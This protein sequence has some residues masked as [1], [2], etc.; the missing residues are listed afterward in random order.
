MSQS[1]LTLYF[2]AEGEEVQQRWMD[3]LSRAGRGEE[4]HPQQP[5]IIESL[6]EEGEELVALEIVHTWLYWTRTQ[7]SE[8]DGAK[9]GPL[10]AFKRKH[11]PTHPPTNTHTPPQYSN[12]YINLHDLPAVKQEMVL[13]PLS[14]LV[15]IVVGGV[16][17]TTVH[18][19]LRAAR[20]DSFNMRTLCISLS[21]WFRL[22]LLKNLTAFF[23]SHDWL[24][25]TASLNAAAFCP[26]HE[27]WYWNTVFIIVKKKTKKTEFTIYNRKIC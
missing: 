2:S 11:T 26:I 24:N 3:V 15:H 22:M 16:S 5:P 17:W 1:H 8:D 23:T 21:L 4:P 9:W 10:V 27:V 6:E 20:E 25:S 7:N 14:I 18:V 19:Y 13:V 12:G